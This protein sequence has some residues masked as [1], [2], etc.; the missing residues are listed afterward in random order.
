MQRWVVVVTVG[1][2][3]AGCSPG[4]SGRAGG[5]PS[6]T[7][8]TAPAPTRT[9]TLLVS[10]GGGNALSGGSSKTPETF[11]LT[12]VDGHVTR[13][14]PSPAPPAGLRIFPYLVR[15]GGIVQVLDPQ[16]GAYDPQIGTAYAVTT[17]WARAVRLGGAS[18]AFPSVHPDRVWLATDSATPDDRLRTY[19]LYGP[20][21]AL[22]EVD[23]T[24]AAT[25]PTYELTGQRSAIAA[26]NGGFLTTVREGALPTPKDTHPPATYHLEVWDPA[27]GQTVRR[28]PDDVANPTATSAQAILTFAT[29]STPAC[30]ARLIDVTTGAER[31]LAPPA[32][33][34]WGGVASFSP[35]GH[36]VS[37]VTRPVPDTAAR[38]G[39]GY[40]PP[41]DETDTAVVYDT[42]TG[43]PIATRRVTTWHGG[44]NIAWSPDSTW[45]FVT[46]DKTH[47]TYAPARFPDVAA[48]I[49]DVPDGSDFLATSPSG[50]SR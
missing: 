9:E 50:A 40:V 17:D 34:A 28:F 47:V 11:H 24:G 14:A 38:S 37:V 43:Q 4:G 6:T 12:D 7:A 13:V 35:D 19:V 39:P 32:G 33:L 5:G 26:V 21:R 10:P 27:T 31:D 44:L 22:A 25:S 15:L 30:P 3:L 8:S 20:H 1:S 16:T 42:A 18:W 23:L 49:V 45:L 41:G 48:A 46:R 29:G 36:L 2:L